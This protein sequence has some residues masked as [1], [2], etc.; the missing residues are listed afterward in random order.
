MNDTWLLGDFTVQLVSVVGS[1]FTSTVTLSPKVLSSLNISCDDN[2]DAMFGD[3]AML[4]VQGK[5]FAFNAT[6]NVHGLL[7]CRSLSF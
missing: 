7:V 4:I 6:S 2:G 1:N 3:I 5:M